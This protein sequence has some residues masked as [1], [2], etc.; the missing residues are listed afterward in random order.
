M[1]GFQSKFL[2]QFHFTDHVGAGWSQVSLSLPPSPTS[3][4][5]V[6]VKIDLVCEMEFCRG[7]NNHNQCLIFWSLW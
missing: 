7:W 2:D 1:A 3:M 4:V 6:Y 5:R